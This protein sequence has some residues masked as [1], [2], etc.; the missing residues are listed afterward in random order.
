MAHH[1]EMMLAQE[2]EAAAAAAGE[3]G[4]GAGGGGDLLLGLGGLRP[5]QE[6]RGGA[7]RQWGRAGNTNRWKLKG[8]SNAVGSSM[9]G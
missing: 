3:A 2:A 7:G 4:G 8:L 6:V 9:K 5:V 1:I